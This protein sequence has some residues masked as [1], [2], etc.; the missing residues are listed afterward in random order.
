M[1]VNTFSVL[2]WNLTYNLTVNEGLGDAQCASE[3]FN[4]LLFYEDLSVTRACEYDIV[5]YHFMI[6]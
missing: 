3:C 6:L 2:I 1:N 5:Q 4:I